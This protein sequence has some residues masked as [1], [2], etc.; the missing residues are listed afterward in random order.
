MNDAPKPNSTPAGASPAMVIAAMTCG[1]KVP[2]SPQAPAAS[3]IRLTR[4]GVRGDVGQD[5]GTASMSL[6]L[7]RVSPDRVSFLSIPALCA[8]FVQ[9]LG[10]G[11]DEANCR[12]K[13][14]LNPLRRDD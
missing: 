13:R 4:R 1:M 2:R 9:K 14:C 7:T 3:R 5:S 11:I 10:D 8:R 6:T 12:R